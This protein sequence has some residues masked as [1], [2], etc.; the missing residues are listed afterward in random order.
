MLQCCLPP[1]FLSPATSCVSPP[2]S[3]L[4]PL[5]SQ[6]RT[7]GSADSFLE[8]QLKPEAFQAAADA[9]GFPVTM[10]MQPGYDHSYF[11][12]ATFIDEHVAFHAK[13]LKGDS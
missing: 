2:H 6:P 1:P 9:A 10:R 11:F 7:P 8:T 3:T 5:P 4:T 12:M 13:S